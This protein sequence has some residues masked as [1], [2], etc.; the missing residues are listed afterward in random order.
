MARKKLEVNPKQ[1][2][3]LKQILQEQNKSQKWLAG[4]INRSEKTISTMVNGSS[5][6][7]S[8]TADLITGLFPAYR[9]EWLLGFDD[10][11]TRTDS[12]IGTLKDSDQIEPED[13][14]YFGVMAF[15][16][17]AGYDVSPAFSYDGSPES[18]VRT[19][20]GGYTISKGNKSIT[21]NLQD[22]H[23][24]CYKIIDYTDFEIQHHNGWIDNIK[25]D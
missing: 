17:S 15:L 11:K 23:D 18:L 10:Y 13:I 19:L 8:E 5:A 21:L 25:S 6:I 20:T 7:T 16:L 4:Q 2:Q 9:K 24:F 12:I 1:S 3:R 22:Y 14:T